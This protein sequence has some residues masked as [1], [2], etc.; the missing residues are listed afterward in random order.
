MRK[1]LIALAGCVCLVLGGCHYQQPVE[2]TPSP[3][4]SPSMDPAIR[5]EFTLPVDP[6]G[7]WDPYS[8]SQSGNMTLLPLLCESLYAL[9]N[10][11]EP[12]PVLAQS[13]LVSEDGL[14]WTV[15][16]R[17]GVTFS[18]GEALTAE[19]VVQAVNAARGEKSAYAKRLSGLKSVSAQENGAVLFQLSTPNSGFLCLLDFPIARV[20]EAGVLGT[21]PYVRAE[22]RLVA[23]SRWWQDKDLPLAEIPLQEA[24]DAD[25]L[26]A[27]FN[28]GTVS[29]AAADPTGADTLGYSGSCQSWEYPTATMVYLGFRCNKGPCKSSEFRRSVAR[30]LDRES[31]TRQALSGHG[32]AA[33]LPVPPTSARYDRTLAAELSRDMAAAGQALE[34]QGYKLGEDG[35]RYSG[36]HPLALTL[37][38]CADNAALDELA[39][40]VA[41][42]LGELGVQV[43]VR[44]LAWEDYKK[45][46]TQGDFDLYLAQSRMTGD[47]DPGPYLTAGSGVCY[48]GFS[49]KT[50]SEALQN[51]R[52]SGEWSGFYT[53]WV[54]D[55]PLASICFKSAGLLTHWGQVQG[56]EPTQGNLFYNFANW[57]IS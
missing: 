14:S 12:Q 10:A 21:G 36:R 49:S 3:S 5:Q 51:A 57:K 28:A 19:T 24:G 34:E 53:Q 37:L 18:D 33:A 32:A 46:L 4:P 39:Q 29:V 11:F 41:A 56:A 42:G 55:V 17:S 1:R 47:L 7:E 54:Q 40:G 30:S 52:K 35:I 15:T 44:S 16:L 31:L 45:A 22:G 25:T 13:A 2:P 48:G 20:T 23:N 27:G 50:L 26:V 38:V 43:S 8:G 9:D 6:V